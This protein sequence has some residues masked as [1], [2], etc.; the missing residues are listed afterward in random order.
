MK[1]KTVPYNT[2]VQFALLAGKGDEVHDIIGRALAEMTSGACQFAQSYP[3]DDLP[4]VVASM[5]VVANALEQILDPD[6]KVIADAIYERT[7][8]IVVNATEF[9]RQAKGGDGNG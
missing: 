7:D 6:G 4:F 5:K 1:K 3:Y 2:Q 8:S 9:M